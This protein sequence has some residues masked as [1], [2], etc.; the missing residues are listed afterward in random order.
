MNFRNYLTINSAFNNSG[1]FENLDEGSHTHFTNTTYTQLSDFHCNLIKKTD[2]MS[3]ESV[4]NFHSVSY[5]K[6]GIRTKIL[7]LY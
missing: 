6:D 4:I 3:C 7:L 5:K 1:N 2:Y